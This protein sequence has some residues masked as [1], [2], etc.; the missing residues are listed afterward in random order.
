[1]PACSG[2]RLCLAQGLGALVF[3]LRVEQVAAADS[4]HVEALVFCQSLF[5]RDFQIRHCGNVS[6][7][8]F[9]ERVPF[10]SLSPGLARAKSHASVQSAV[11]GGAFNRAEAVQGSVQDVGLSLA[12]TALGVYL[13]YHQK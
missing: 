10:F 2:S 13:P 1:M 8:R 7:V 9:R 4:R 6:L 11:C 12:E 3:E 5:C